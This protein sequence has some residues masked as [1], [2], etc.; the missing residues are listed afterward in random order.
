METR[1]SDDRFVIRESRPGTGA[2]LFTLVNLKKK[3]FIL[4]YTGVRIPSA[5]AD[6][7]PSRYLFE[8][9]EHWTLD[10]ESHTNEARWINHDCHPNVEAEIEDGKIMIYAQKK[11]KAGEELT[12]DYDSEYFDEF[13]RPVG[14]KC[15]S[16]EKGLPSPH[17]KEGT[18]P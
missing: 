9:D 11:I 14:C 17:M 5:I 10:G 6:D 2:G 12:I 1:I 13:I 3:D 4:E 18:R 7:S 16:C 15:A 8:V